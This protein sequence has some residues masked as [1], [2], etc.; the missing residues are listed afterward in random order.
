MRLSVC[1]V[2][3]DTELQKGLK[4][5]KIFVI[6]INIPCKT[7]TIEDNGRLHEETKLK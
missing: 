5:P 2:F 3:Q 1:L 7:I 4:T 6:W